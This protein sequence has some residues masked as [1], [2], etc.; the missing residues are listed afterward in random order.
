MRTFAEGVAAVLISVLGVADG[1]IGGFARGILDLARGILGLAVQ[2]L[3]GACCL[4]GAAGNLGFRITGH[5]ANRAFDFTGG[6]LGRA[7]DSILIHRVDSLKLSV[8]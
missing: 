3:H 8:G 6:I 5:I 4:A 2:I 1:G 7:G